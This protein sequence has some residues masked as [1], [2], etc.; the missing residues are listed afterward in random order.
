M[1]IDL[2]NES[3]PNKDK[4]DFCIQ[5]M[6]SRVPAFADRIHP[7]YEVLQW[8][9]MRSGFYV[10]PVSEIRSTL[11]RLIEHL[12]EGKQCSEISTGGLF[13]RISYDGDREDGL[14]CAIGMTIEEME[15]SQ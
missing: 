7:V 15:W 1:I 9:W 13:A 6:R 10:P 4:F 12:E 3:P 14:E 5:E 8:H 2:L 11:L